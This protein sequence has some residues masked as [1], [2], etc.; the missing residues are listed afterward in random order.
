[1]QER[2]PDPPD[3]HGPLRYSLDRLA[4]KPLTIPTCHGH[5]IIGS[6]HR[7]GKRRITVKL[8]PSLDISSG[9]AVS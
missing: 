5:V 6:E 9:D 2:M 4:D 3:E 1:M 7:N 8:P